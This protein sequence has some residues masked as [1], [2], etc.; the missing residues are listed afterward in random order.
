MD[1]GLAYG[2]GLFE[3]IAIRSGRPCCWLDHLDR[4]ALGAARLRLP[5]PSPAQLKAEAS[6]LA[7]AVDIG[8]L[9]ILLTRGPSVRG[10]RPPSQP[11]PT[12]ILLVDALPEDQAGPHG[13]GPVG[14]SVD[15]SAELSVEHSIGPP[16]GNQVDHTVDLRSEQG[17]C[18]RLCDIRLGINP[19]LA[20]L[21]HLNRLEQVLARAEW[22]EPS[23]DEGLMLD[24]DGTLVC[25]TMS[26]LFL[27]TAAGLQTPL[28]D[29]CG[30]AGTARARMINAAREAGLRAQELRLTVDDL[31]KAQGAF[32]TNA[33]IGVWP[34]RSFEGHDFE[35]SL[36]PWPLIN[37]VRGCLLQPESD[38]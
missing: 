21:K 25:G 2:D 27:V 7:A 26:N 15:S 11:K 34:I 33:L 16:V 22:S 37:R 6:Q 17:I 31:L 38:W 30:V 24:A 32:L 13:D 8:T 12:R 1:R 10:Y 36:L 35:L 5:L 20:G 4:L 3:T 23:I 14:H 19:Q 9:K 29:R 18:A 28:I